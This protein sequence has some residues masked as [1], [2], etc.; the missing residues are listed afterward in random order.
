MPNEDH[1]AIIKRGVTDWNEWRLANPETEPD[2]RYANLIGGLFNNANLRNA[3][4]ESATLVCSFAGADLRQ[5]NLRGATLSGAY[6]EGADLGQADLSGA[7]L[8]GTN[9]Q[10]ATLEDAK[11]SGTKF[12]GANLSSARLDRSRGRASFVEAN[13]SDAS[14]I[15]CDFRGIGSGGPDFR[16][17]NLKKTNLT[18]A[19]LTEADL[20]GAT[21]VETV[22][23][24]ANI[25]WAFVY[26]V[27][28]WNISTVNLIKRDLTITPM[29]E[30]ER[31]LR[32]SFVEKLL[33]GDGPFSD[34]SRIT[35]DN[36]EV[37]QFIYLIL[38]NQKIRDVINT[39]TSK[40]VLILGR[41]TPPE[42]KVILTA[43]KEKLRQMN[44]LPI[45]FDFERPTDRDF[46]E[47]LM[48]LT[49]MS[50]FVIAD[51][52]NP[53]SSPLELQTTVPNYM[54]PFVPILQAG[55]TPFSMFADLQNKY[56]WV[57]DVRTYDTQAQLIRCFEEAIVKPALDK[58]DQLLANKMEN[59]RSIKITEVSNKGHFMSHN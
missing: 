42:R 52:T 36:L 45:V 34:P 44:F 33:R 20:E 29:S 59:M 32:K 26:G 17:A 2:L 21:L 18:S 31:N 15:G 37:A 40:A 51:I 1:F 16:R 53:K 48:T 6:L 35:V 11:L 43:M 38:N 54:V 19:N 46:T 3:N 14:L 30:D 27:S 5:A 50:L 41:F 23:D 58:H 9:L 12:L 49:G 56:G 25:S 55:E 13:L 28:A 24:G 22:L 4:L 47:T 39:I 8:K 57:L 10:E 7:T